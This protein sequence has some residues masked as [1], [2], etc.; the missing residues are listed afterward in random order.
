[1]INAD[2]FVPRLKNGDFDLA[3][4][5]HRGRADED[6]A[7]FFATGGAACTAWSCTTAG[8]RSATSAWRTD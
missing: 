3:A 4:I 1:V 7:P 6:L 5:D 8:W 2:D